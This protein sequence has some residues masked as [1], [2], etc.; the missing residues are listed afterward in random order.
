MVAPERESYQSE[1]E[2]LYFSFKTPVLLAVVRDHVHG[3]NTAT[4]VHK[5]SRH[6][7]AIFGNCN[8]LMEPYGSAAISSTRIGLQNA[9][10]AVQM[11]SRSPLAAIACVATLLGAVWTIRDYNAWISFGTGGTPPN[12][13]GYWKITKLRLA[14]LFSR[15]K[16]RDPTPLD[17]KGPGPSFLDNIPQRKGGRPVILPRP[18]PQRQQPEPIPPVTKDRLMSLMNKMQSEYPEL[19]VLKK[20]GTEG[21]SAEAIYAKPDLETL[22]PDT[23]VLKL[24]LAHAHP[25]D[26]SLHLLL[27]AVDAAKVIR[28]EWGERFPLHYV[29]RNDAELDVIEKIVR[30]S[31]AYGTGV[32]ISK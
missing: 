6:R 30:A 32:P 28:A 15:R 24:E 2:V 9:A 23:H 19:L 8:L 22:G 3:M 27:S 12:L 25:Q 4:R 18:L 11:L 13:S 1:K 21:G 29:P 31:I 20:S 16:L 10:R 17:F 7:P 14:R 5:R 26:A